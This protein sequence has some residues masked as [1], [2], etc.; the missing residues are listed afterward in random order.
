VGEVDLNEIFCVEAVRTVG[1]DN[2]VTMAGLAL[3]IPAQPG[4]HTCAGLHVIVRQHLDGS[5]SICRGTQVFGRYDG[6]GRLLERPAE[7]TTHQNDPGTTISRRNGV[8]V[9]ASFNTY[10][11]S[12]RACGSRRSCGK[13]QTA[14]VSHEDLGRRQ[15]ASA[16]TATTGP[17]SGESLA[18]ADNSLVKTDRTD[19]LLSTASLF[20]EIHG[21]A[22]V[23]RPS[24]GRHGLCGLSGADSSRPGSSEVEVAPEADRCLRRMHS[25]GRRL[26]HA[27]DNMRTTLGSPFRPW[28]RESRCC[29]D[30][31]VDRLYIATLD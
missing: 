14:A 6:H 12:R 17:T 24:R 22:Q 1:K 19:H 11:R 10:A 20:M 28:R 26:A 29:L 21:R 9:G 2:V 18:K 15:T 13:P 5:Y 27:D 25:P 23:P 8:K 3:Q 7:K 30:R 31:E 16:S 4:R